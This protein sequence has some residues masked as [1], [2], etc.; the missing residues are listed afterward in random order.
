MAKW[1]DEKMAD[2]TRK[3]ADTTIDYKAR[4][5]ELEAKL[6]KSALQEIAA[7]GQ[8][9]E[10]YQAQLAAEAK[11]T[12]AVEAL[13]RQATALDLIHEQTCTEETHNPAI[14]AIARGEMEAIEATLAAITAPK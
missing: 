13:R 7:L 2:L 9:S 8:A 5:E 1:S 14:A 6:R 4:C 12:Q 11:L 10:A 3:L